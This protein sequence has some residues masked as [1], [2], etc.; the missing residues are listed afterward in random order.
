MLP[1]L[2]RGCYIFW[3]EKLINMFGI[4]FNHTHYDALLL[5]Q[6]AKFNPALF[7]TR[8]AEL[9]IN[10]ILFSV[11]TLHIGFLPNFLVQGC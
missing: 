8:H 7:V 4:C 2:I 9:L 11:H 10:A 3:F 1:T 5:T 6:L